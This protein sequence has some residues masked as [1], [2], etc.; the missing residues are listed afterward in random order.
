M[1]KILLVLLLVSNMGLA[2]DYGLIVGIGNYENI[3][4][5]DKVDEDIAIYQKI[6]EHRKIT[7]YVVLKNSFATKKAILYNL[8]KIA[9]KIKKGD[10][11]FMFFSGHGTSLQDVAY[12]EVL[13]NAGL[14]YDMRD[15]GAILPYDFNKNSISKTIIIGKRDLR[16]ILK[17]IDNKNISK[18]LIIF[19]ACFAGNSIRDKSGRK[20]NLTPNILT[21]INGYPYKNIDYIASSIIEATPGKFS[22][23]LKDCLIKHSDLE[24]QKI[25][26]SEKVNSSMLPAVLVGSKN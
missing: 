24:N 22:P 20:V 11:F 6:L 17:K 18:G 14:S 21:H 12:T 26:I 1:K 4:K 5:L 2:V 25:C 7:D 19:D 13:Q 16:N 8:N 10:N 23:I 15:S 9:N 3:G